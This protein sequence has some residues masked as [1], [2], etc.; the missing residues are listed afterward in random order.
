MS[1]ATQTDKLSVDW[2]NHQRYRSVTARAAETKTVDE[3]ATKE[4][5]GKT[6]EGTAYLVLL[7]KTAHLSWVMII[8]DA[9]GIPVAYTYK[10]IWWQCAANPP[11]LISSQ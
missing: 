2:R 3:S 5:S 7:H 8:D 11:M 10:G 4:T 1:S 6:L 9:K